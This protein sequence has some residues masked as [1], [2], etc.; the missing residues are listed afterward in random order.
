MISL[1]EALATRDYWTVGPRWGKGSRQ[2]ALLQYWAVSVLT[3]AAFLER[4]YFMEWNTSAPDGD[5]GSKKKA[6]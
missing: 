5:L 1:G 2:E 4:R 3:E 6:D